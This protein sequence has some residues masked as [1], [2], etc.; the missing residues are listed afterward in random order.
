MS[1][2][3]KIGPAGLA[4][5]KSSE[6]FSAIPYV[7]PATGNLPITCG[8]GSTHKIDGTK[9]KLNDKAISEKEGEKLLLA[10]LHTYEQAVDACCVDTLTQNMFDSLVSLVYNI[11]PANFKSS[12]LVKKINKDINDPTIPAEFLRWNKA[13]GK[14]MKGLTIRR[15]KES[16]LFVS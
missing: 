4:L 6:G 2:I 9:F 13:A 15:Q 16:V 10:T 1:K 8:Y 7:D 3:T 5:I 14:V 12:T 11:G